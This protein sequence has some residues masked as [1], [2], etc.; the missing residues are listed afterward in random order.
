MSSYHKK[1]PVPPH[2]WGE[3]RVTVDEGDRLSSCITE[4][5]FIPFVGA[6]YIGIEPYYLE[7]HENGEDTP[8]ILKGT[9]ENEHDATAILACQVIQGKDEPL[10]H[11]P[12]SEKH[13]IA[14]V[15]PDTW[16]DPG[17]RIY[18]HDGAWGVYVRFPVCYL[19][20]YLAYNSGSR[21]VE[22]RERL[23]SVS[24]RNW[25][26]CGFKSAR[27]YDLSTKLKP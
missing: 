23:N 20:G 14:H 24:D 18:N 8:I 7:P 19:D 2:R 6:K 5:R 16:G 27:A 9:P 17:F 12:R 13:W 21:D 3:F 4:S 11:I 1:A 25:W 15:H 10:G 22:E 26:L